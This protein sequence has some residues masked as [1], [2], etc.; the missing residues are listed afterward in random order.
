LRRIRWA[1]AAADDLQSIHGYLK[2]HHPSFA[3]STVRKLY[4]AARSLK[5]L[6]Y[7]GRVGHLDHT[8]E[9]VMAP[10]PYLIVYGVEPDVIHI[11]RVIHTSEDWP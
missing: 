11:F 10:L 6:P 3:N 7:R 2:E 4:A 5:R 9:L 8:R 1:P